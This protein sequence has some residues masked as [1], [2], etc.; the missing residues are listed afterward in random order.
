MNG[1]YAIGDIHG[2]AEELDE[3]LKA[4]PLQCGDTLVFIGDYLDRGPSSKAV[5][6]R[7]IALKHD[8]PCDT[9]FLKG[10][11]EDMFLAYMGLSGNYGDMFLVNGGA[12]TLASYGLAPQTEPALIGELIPRDHLDFLLNLRLSFETGHWFFVHAGIHPLWPLEQQKEEDLLWI[13]NEFIYNIHRVPRT[14][15]F[16]HTPQRDILL[17]LPYK[18]GIDTGVVYGNT[19]SCLDL[20]RQLLYQVQR[21]ERWVKR[22]DLRKDFR[23]REEPLGWRLWNSSL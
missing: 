17:D 15:V 11:H 23:L 21:G 16:G 10:N 18:I 12:A 6:S 9:V 2:C 8:E 14:V 1:L 7:L 3:L 13:R 20:K 22:R 5:L 4:I 19:L